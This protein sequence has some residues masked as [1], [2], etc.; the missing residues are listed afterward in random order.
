[1]TVI[2]LIQK[3]QV[4]TVLDSNLKSISF[5]AG[6]LKYYKKNASN[7]YLIGLAYECLI[8]LKSLRSNRVKGLSSIKHFNSLSRLQRLYSLSS[9]L[10]EK[11]FIDKAFNEY[12]KAVIVI[13][14]Y[15]RKG[16]LSKKVLKSILI[17]L[18]LN[19]IRNFKDLYKSRK[20]SKKDI[21]DLLVL[22]KSLNKFSFLF[23]GDI[24]FNLSLEYL[25]LF[26][27]LDIYYKSTILDIKTVKSPYFTKAMRNQL[28]IYFIL[29][30]LN[31]FKIK[32]VGI[33]FSRHGKVF[34]LKKKKLFKKK[35]FSNLKKLISQGKL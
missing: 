33:L 19:K 29:A 30:E 35:G 20:V 8:Q 17:L 2:G 3:K 7:Y 21:S 10:K 9:N 32:K 6:K 22:K 31:G 11:Q 34:F 26:G 24:S 5:N 28:A 13:Q 1:M 15:L 25:Y 23:S 4:K 27:E 14:E 18:Y 16:K 12:N